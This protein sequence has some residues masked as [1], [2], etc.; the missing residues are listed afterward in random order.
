MRDHELSVLYIIPLRLVTF[1]LKIQ[2][3]E[4]VKPIDFEQ[5]FV[6]IV[7]KP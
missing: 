6:V 5:T 2:W 4:K 3:V 1:F 7:T